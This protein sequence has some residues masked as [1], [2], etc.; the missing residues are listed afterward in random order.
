MKILFT[1]DLHSNKEAFRSFVSTLDSQDSD[2]GV[3]AG[4]LTEGWIPIRTLVATFGD[5]STDDFLPELCG[6]D[7]PAGSAVKHVVTVEDVLKRGLAQEEKELKAI[8]QSTKKP[9]L[10]VRGNHDRTAWNSEGNIHNIHGRC[11]RIGKMVFVGLEQSRSSQIKKRFLHFVSVLRKVVGKNMIL[12][13][14]TPPLTVLDKTSCGQHLGTK[15]ILE[16]VCSITPKFHLFGH[17]HEQSG[18][19]GGFINGSFPIMRKFV[20]INVETNSIDFLEVINECNRCSCRE[21]SW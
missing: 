8:L 12:V 2:V 18:V 7:D 16:L 20:S 9:I 21:V 11:V 13:T 14:H 5:I 6:P 17:I 10:I 1:A 15:E 19:R 4:D 3:I